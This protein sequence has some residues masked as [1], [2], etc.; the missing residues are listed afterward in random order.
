MKDVLQDK[1]NEET[2]VGRREDY[3][4]Y[5]HFIFPKTITSSIVAGKFETCGVS[6]GLAEGV[7]WTSEKI[8]KEKEGDKKAILYTEGLSP[9]LARYF[10]RIGGILSNNGSLVY[11]LAILGPGKRHTRVGW[12]FFG[13][14]GVKIGDKIRMDGD[15][16][17]ITKL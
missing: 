6:S 7:L 8:E 12:F 2:F 9:D 11:P 14:K 1:I 10:N 15:T 4:K 17:E 16:G 13:K 5:N 3:K